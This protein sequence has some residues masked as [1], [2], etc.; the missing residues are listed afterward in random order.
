MI[1]LLIA[2]KEG[3]DKLLCSA[4]IPATTYLVCVPNFCHV[5]AE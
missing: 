3:T 1:S 5:S 2:G 4:S